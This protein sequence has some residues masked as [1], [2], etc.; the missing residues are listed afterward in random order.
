MSAMSQ[1]VDRST[2]AAASYQK[3][4]ATERQ[5]LSVLYDDIYVCHMSSNAE[6]FTLAVILMRIG[7]TVP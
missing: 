3:R 6:V 4:R 7:R 5:P 2:P 1:D